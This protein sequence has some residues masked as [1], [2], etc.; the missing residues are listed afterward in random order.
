MFLP[1]ITSCVTEEFNAD[2][3]DPTLQINPGV[4]APIGWAKYRLDEILLDS[5]NPGEMIIGSDGF[6]TMIYHGNLASLQAFEIISIEDV[7]FEKILDNPYGMAVDLNTL[8][9]SEGFNYS[10]PLQLTFNGTENAA[11]DSI[12]VR[13]GFM[14]LNA[15]P[16]YPDL[17]WDVRFG[18]PGIPDFQVTLD[19]D[20]TSAIDTLDGE[21]LPINPADN[22]IP[23]EIILTLNKSSVT[24]GPGPIIDISI[25]ISDADYDVIYG[26]LGQFSVNAGPISFPVDFYNRTSGGTFHFSDPK[27]TISFLNSFGLPI[28]VDTLS[29]TAIGRE[30]QDSTITGP[31]IPVPSDHRILNYPQQGEE[32]QT[33]ADSIILDNSKTDLFDVLG[34]SPGEISVRMAGTANPDGETHDNFLLDTSRLSIST[35][36]LLPLDGYADLLLIADTL[37][38]IFAGFYENPPEEI[39]RLIFRLDFDRLLPVDVSTQLYFLDQNYAMLDSLFHDEGDPRKIVAGSPIDANGIATPDNPPDPVEIELTREQIDNISACYF[40]LA[41]GEVTTTGYNSP[42]NPAEVRFYSYYFLDTYVSA[43]AELEM[44]SDNY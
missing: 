6:I 33:M 31:G 16:R 38:F 36:L 17:N 43:I 10:I 14:T 20:H 28:Q 40:I 19:M 23:M 42:D 22:T 13:T 26:Y 34:T 29:F 3:V 18:I 32:G 35:E 12:L 21:M 8:D 7:N 2:L 5:L 24:I 44:N 37:D 1:A 25:S 39:K 11:V 41:K 9:S 4:A 27:L 15:S 30:G